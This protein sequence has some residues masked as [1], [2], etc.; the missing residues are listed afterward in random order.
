MT[1]QTFFLDQGETLGGA[2]RF[3]LD[4]LERLTVKETT[5]MKPVVI[6]AKNKLYIEKINDKVSFIDFKYPS[7]RAKGLGKIFK[8]L[9]LMNAARKF[10]QLIRSHQSNR[11]KPV[12]WANTP[13]TIFLSYLAKRFWSLD[14]QLII[15][16]HDFTIPDFLLRRIARTADN[17]VVNSVLTRQKVRDIA[18][19]T[20]HSKISI[21]E[22]GIDFDSIPKA[23]RPKKI[24][25]ILLI[26]RIDPRKGQKYAI[27]A[28]DLL[29][30]RNPDLNFFIV[31]SPFMEDPR[32]VAYDQEIKQF[33]NDRR[34]K[35]LFFI[36]EVADPFEA[37]AKADLV[38]VL[39]TEP[40]T[41]GR[42]TIEALSQG[43]MVVAFN[44]DGPKQVLESF[45]KFAKANAELL[46]CE[47]GNAMSLA[48]KIG[49][50]ADNPDETEIY[51]K[52]ARKFT[53]KYFDFSETK[54]RMTNILLGK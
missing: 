10:T 45:A 35:N 44:Q 39:P 20:D 37:F 51:T 21:I 27:E 22:N 50:L 13:R 36:D 6:G 19:S 4:F 15:M 47:V 38:L 25:S 42:V 3:L 34:L 52:N 28:A 30:E 9:G 48:E 14:C 29:L 54:K 1:Y 11:R 32:T 26:G 49:Y 8:G 23:S 12:I 53:E 41:F 2:E 24:E 33:A 43:K 40:E 31:G 17:I 7:V 46:L 16:I 5:K 18:H